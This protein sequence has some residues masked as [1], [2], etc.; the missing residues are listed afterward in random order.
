MPSTNT[1]SMVESELI[2]PL[3]HAERNAPHVFAVLLGIQSEFERQMCRI[4]RPFQRRPQRILHDPAFHFFRA[5][6]RF[7]L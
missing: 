2:A 6:S 7:W 4:L 3:N 1:G 5:A